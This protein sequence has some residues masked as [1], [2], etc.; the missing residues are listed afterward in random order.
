MLVL[1]IWLWKIQIVIVQE[2][3]VRK[4]AIF[5]IT[6]L[7]LCRKLKAAQNTFEQSD[8]FQ[9]FLR[10]WTRIFEVKKEN[11]KVNKI[12]CLGLGNFA[13]NPH[14]VSAQIASKFQLS[15]LLAL[16]KT[17]SVQGLV[18]DP[19]LT[20]SEKE[21][22]TALG[23]ESPEKN[24]E[25][26]YQVDNLTLFY[27]PHCPKQLTNNILWANWESLQNLVIIGNSFNSCVLHLSKR[28]LESVSY[29]RQASKFVKGTNF[30][31]LSNSQF[32]NFVPFSFAEEIIKNNFQYPDVFNNLSLHRFE[33]NL[34]L[35]L[36]K[37]SD[38]PK[39]P[40]TDLE[41]IPNGC[42]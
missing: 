1:K 38:P 27:L 13:Q 22:L 36:S 34:N 10:T 15:F 20:K 40:E 17:H 31:I 35:N 2:I 16:L 5:T 19:V 41:F 6:D 30:S 42:H 12:I 8:F 14:S 37:S 29:L 23:I 18:F 28:Q 21:I 24:L 32:F 11:K 3:K 33:S 7:F 25:G 9:D 39:Y 4:S 26:R